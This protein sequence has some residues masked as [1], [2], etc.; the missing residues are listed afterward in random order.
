MD[1]PIIQEDINSELTGINKGEKE[2]RRKQL[3]IG[4][5]VGVLFLAIIIFIIVVA[6][7]GS[8]GGGGDDDTPYPVFG[9]INCL[10]E[11]RTTTENTLLLSN[12]FVKNSG[13]DIYIDNKKI[14]YSKEYKFT[15]V[16]N[17][18]VKIKLYEGINMDYMFKDIK[19]LLTVEMISEDNCQILSM[20][21]TFE[22]CFNLMDFK[23]SGFNVENLK[24]TKKLFYRSSLV[25]FHLKALIQ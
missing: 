24:S 5:A 13:F 21:S 3:I 16:G 25:T 15:S 9:E 1:D 10:Y 7:S 17:H 14:K 18:N 4:V 2:E 22:N 8:K 23:I 20:I 6:A 12:E 11:I 19:E